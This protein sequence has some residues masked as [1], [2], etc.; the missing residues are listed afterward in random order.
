MAE[1]TKESFDKAIKTLATKRSLNETTNSLDRVAR[2]LDSTVSTVNR[3]VALLTH[4]AEHTDALKEDMKDV[5]ATVQSHTGTLDK[6]LKN[7][8]D[9]KTE[10][11]SLRSAVK[12]HE[13]WITPV[14]KKVG[15]RLEDGETKN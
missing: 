6:I 1:L 3:T 15:I 4:V 12:R 2:T 13:Q 7:S 11:A 9:W 5:K 10:A 8:E 14:A